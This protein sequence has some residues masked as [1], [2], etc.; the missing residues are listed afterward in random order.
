[1]SEELLQKEI[2][3]FRQDSTI[4][5]AKELAARLDY[6]QDCIVGV[7]DEPPMSLSSIAHFRTFIHNYN[8]NVPSLVLTQNNE[9]A[10][11]WGRRDSLYFIMSFLDDERVDFL[12]NKN[13]GTSEPDISTG[14]STLTNIINDLP[15][16]ECRQLIFSN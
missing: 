15:H 1:M 4:P 14:S 6:L 8:V 2:D 9:I 7:E 3:T 5:Y 10:A 16:P 11:T 13:Q 12:C